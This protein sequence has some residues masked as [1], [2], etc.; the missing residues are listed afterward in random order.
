VLNL[1]APLRRPI[2]SG[3]ARLAWPDGRAGDD[4]LEPRGEPALLASDSITWQVFKNPLA[5]FI[6]GVTA[7]V[8]ELG[9][10][11]VRTGVWLYTSFR[12]RPLERMQRT[13]HAALM[14]VYG[15]R[16]RAESMIRSVAQRHAHV[17]GVTPQGRAFRATDPELLEWVHATACF[18]FVAAY[19]AY[20]RPLAAS[21][22]D[23]F[24][25]ESR[26]A[27]DRYGATEVPD[28]TAALEGLFDRMAAQLEPSS[29]VTDFLG[30]VR[31]MPALPPPLR[32]FQGV[33]VRAAVD[34][35][36]ERLRDR[37]GLG[38]AWRLAAWERTLVRAAGDIV[39]RLVLGTNPAVHACRRLGLPA[40]H[41]Y[42]R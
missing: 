35:V 17:H 33:L 11:R 23:R 14:T 34:L 13:G 30:I 29:I 10:P 2:E 41:L 38:A 27:A 22:R 18:G 7:V 40:D 12:E 4:F 42:R 36:P 9:E 15:P 19:H 25:S 21:E 6:G 1:P 3:L 28:S 26:P 16:S 31:R 37:I 24:Y 5:L 39:D 20:V 8:L 32:P